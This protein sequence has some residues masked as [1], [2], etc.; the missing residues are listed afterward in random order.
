[1][2][3]EVEIVD[4]GSGVGCIRNHHY[5]DGHYRGSA[6][7]QRKV[8]YHRVD[9]RMVGRCV[10]TRRGGDRSVHNADHLGNQQENRSVG[11]DCSLCGL[12]CGVCDHI[13]FRGDVCI[14][15]HP[16]RGS[17]GLLRCRACKCGSSGIAGT[18]DRRG[19]QGICRR[20]SR[21]RVR[22]AL[23]V[24][25]GRELF[26]V[27]SIRVRRR[28]QRSRVSRDCRTSALGSCD[29]TPVVRC[30]GRDTSP[31]ARVVDHSF[32]HLRP[33]QPCSRCTDTLPNTSAK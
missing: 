13:E 33:S 23:D 31:A 9:C 17:S 26:G 1:M 6:S 21:I 30:T 8:R 19:D 12:Q 32:R 2:C 3:R 7:D 25:F 5:G 15:D 18:G 4:T 16:R 28:G 14:S 10:C 11:R 22:R 29:T 27:D 20:H 24:L